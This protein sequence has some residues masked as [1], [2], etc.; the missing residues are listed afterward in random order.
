LVTQREGGEQLHE[1]LDNHLSH[2]DGRRHLGIDVEAVQKVFDGLEQ[3]N[4][5]FVAVY[6]ALDRL[7]GLDVTKMRT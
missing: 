2:G 1:Y 5:C 6:G 3:I 4:Q 7:I